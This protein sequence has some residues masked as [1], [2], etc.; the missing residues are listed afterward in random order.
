MNRLRDHRGKAD[1]RLSELLLPSRLPGD[2]RNDL[3]AYAGY[4]HRLADG[5]YSLLPLGHRVLR[6]IRRI[7]RQEMASVGAQELTMPLL[8]PEWLWRARADMFGPQL[9]RLASDGEE[10]LILAPTHEEVA[11]VLAAACIQS[12]RDLP[13]LFYQIQP[14]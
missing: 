5:L 1:M 2:D 10:R 4:T 12:A 9:F 14:R 13:R 11:S 6:R 8:Q 3:L 7:V